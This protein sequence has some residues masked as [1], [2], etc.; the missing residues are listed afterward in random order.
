MKQ[1]PDVCYLVSVPCSTVKLVNSKQGR[2]MVEEVFKV[3]LKSEKSG[4]LQQ[5]M[6]FLIVKTL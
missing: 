2:D 4:F 6:K 5:K 3:K 1:L